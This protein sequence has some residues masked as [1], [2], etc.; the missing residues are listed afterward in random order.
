MAEDTTG[1]EGQPQLHGSGREGT[2]VV[3]VTA[4]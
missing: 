3:M 1:C 4:A 2:A